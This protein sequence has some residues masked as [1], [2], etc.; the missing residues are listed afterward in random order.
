LQEHKATLN[1]LPPDTV[2]TSTLRFEVQDTGVGIKEEQLVKILQP[3][4]Q[5]GSKEQRA[6]GTGLGLA[7]STQLVGLMGSALT[8]ISAIGEGSTFSFQLTLPLIDAAPQKVSNAKSII[9]YQGA[10]QKILVVDDKVKNR[11]V[12]CDI[13]IPLGF[14]VLEA[15]NGLAA[16]KEARAKQPDLIL[17][18]LIMPVMN[19]FDA[20]KRMRQIASLQKVPIIAI[21]ASVFEQHQKESLQAG[22]DAF[23]PK[24]I[25]LEVLLSLLKSYLAIEWLYAESPQAQAVSTD[26]LPL[27]PPPRQELEALQNLA[28]RGNVL[29]LRKQAD[30]IESL[31]EKY[32]SF[33][34][35]LRTLAKQFKHKQILALVEEY[36]DHNS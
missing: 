34:T 26:A 22:C 14:E 27:I 16:I 13:L 23:L 21:S 9:G 31:D 5:V 4:E 17:T 28:K 11:F 18:D 7:I 19:G 29:R 33:A 36:L 24:P 32:L 6:E 12:L 20:V 3:F 15:E 1:G 10:R 2:P 25:R 30:Y 8:V 35:K